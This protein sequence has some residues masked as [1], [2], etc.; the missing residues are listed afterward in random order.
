MSKLGRNDKC[1]CGSD[2]KYKKCCGRESE[3][4]YKNICLLVG[5]GFVI[6][7]LKSMN[8]DEIDS[9]KPLQE[10]CCEDIDYSAFIDDTPELKA[11]LLTLTNEYENDFEAIDYFIATQVGQQDDE[12]FFNAFL[13]CNTRRF[14]ANA[15]SLLYCRIRELMNSNEFEEWKWRQWIIENGNKIK[16]A[17]SFNYD[18][19]LEKT[20][21]RCN[22][23]YKRIGTIED[24][25]RNSIPVLKPHGSID[26]DIP[27]VFGKVSRRSSILNVNVVYQ[28]ADYAQLDI[29]PESEWH[30]CRAVAPIIPPLQYN[31]NL[32]LDWVKEIN[33]YFGDAARDIDAFILVGFSYYNADQP[34]V[35][36]FIDACSGRDEA[37]DFFIVNPDRNNPNTRQ[38]AEYIEAKGHNVIKRAYLPWY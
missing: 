7:Y 25:R 23:D 15:Y 16:I 28:G 4:D 19:I 26:F 9:S 36:S 27:D 11:G 13:Y 14:L 24:N 1:I 6:D 2:L 17:I 30:G 3:N 5:N 35:N 31:D 10:F 33:R 37:I 21:E 12:E 34:E 32:D 18:L 29:L 22:L 38:L 8:A 20:F